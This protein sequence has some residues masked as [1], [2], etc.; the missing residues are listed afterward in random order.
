MNVNLDD[1]TCMK[2]CEVTT[3]VAYALIWTIFKKDLKFEFHT[4]TRF[5]T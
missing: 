5:I 2:K 4:Q 1:L 3:Q